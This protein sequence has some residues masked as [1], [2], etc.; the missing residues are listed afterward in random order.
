MRGEVQ[1]TAQEVKAYSVENTLGQTEFTEALWM[2]SVFL[3]LAEVIAFRMRP[4]AP[5]GLGIT[6]V[7]CL[8]LKEVGKCSVIPDQVRNDG[9]GNLP[10]TSK[11][12]NN[13]CLRGWLNR[14][15][16]APSAGRQS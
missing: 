7:K 12:S 3:T 10:T 15:C 9:S 13:Y 8:N 1:V 5:S 11:V 6:T 2:V 16:E 14:R 4:T